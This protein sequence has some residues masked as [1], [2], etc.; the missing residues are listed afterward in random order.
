MTKQVAAEEE[1]LRVF[2]LNSLTVVR[3]AAEE[4]DRE[5]LRRASSSHVVVKQSTLL[6]IFCLP[7]VK[8]LTGLSFMARDM[9][10]MKG[11]RSRTPLPQ[12]KSYAAVH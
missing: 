5:L 11:K 12:E 9:Y 6:H 8:R 3:P 2:G 1:S 10:R 7:L 4:S